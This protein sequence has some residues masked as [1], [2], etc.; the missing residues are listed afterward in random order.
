MGTRAASLLIEPT[1][2]LL[3]EFVEFFSLLEYVVVLHKDAFSGLYFLTCLWIT[4][5]A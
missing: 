4:Y 5:A 1:D 3:F 2:S